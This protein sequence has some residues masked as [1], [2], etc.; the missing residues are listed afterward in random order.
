MKIS[1]VNVL[2][3][4]FTS[5]TSATKSPTATRVGLPGGSL[6]PRVGL[7]P[8]AAVNLAAQ[9]LRDERTRVPAAVTLL[10]AGSAVFEAADPAD[11]IKRMRAAAGA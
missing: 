11:V 10:V 5:V 6:P 2:S 9:A 8:L 7:P 1:I 4:S 3:T